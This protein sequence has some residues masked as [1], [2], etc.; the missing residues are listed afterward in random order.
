MDV[1]IREVF[2]HP[3][4]ADLAAAV[5]K[6]TP[7]TLPPI[8]AAQRGERLPLSFAQQ[9]LWFLA[10]IG[11]S[12]A[13]HIFYGLRLKGQLDRGALRRALDRIVARHE[14]L[15]TTFVS[16]EG[17]PAQRIAAAEESRFHLVEHDLPGHQMRRK[18]WISGQGRGGCE[19]D[20]ESRAADPR[21]I[22]PD[23]GRGACAADHDAPH[24][25]RRMVDGRVYQGVERAL[26]G[27]CARGSGPAA[28]AGSLQY[29]D[30]AVWQRKWMEGEILRKQGEYWER[31][32]AGAPAL[33]ELPADHPRPAEQEYAGGGRVALDEDLTRGLKELSKKHGTTLYMTLMAGWGALLARL[34]GQEDIVIGTP[35]ANRGRMEIEGLI[36]FFVNTLA[37]R[38]DVSGS[39]S[40]GDLLKRVKEQT[41]SAQQNQDIP[42]EQVVE[43]VRPVRS[44]VHSPL[45]QVMFDWQQNIGGGGLAL[46]GLEF[47]PLGSAAH[48]VAKFDLT[49]S[50]RDAGERIVGGLVYATGL[51]ERATMERY[52]GYLGAL[53]EGMVAEETQA[54]DR[55][56]LLPEAERRQ[57][58]N[59]WNATEAEYPREKLVHELFEEQVE[60]TPEAVAVVL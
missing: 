8:T 10:Q 44:L 54:V 55:L 25:F 11:A 49:L 18:N 41:L 9:R 56:Q 58:V 5:Q 40:V 7:A 20:L 26:R 6:A 39:P 53:L 31:T 43:V 29:A 45:F 4:L 3:V 19:F 32:L 2:E 22:D 37:L 15:R 12:E 60:K 42:F 21:A 59:E 46:P 27:V 23:G 36:G 33:L 1:T 14:A 16:I 13:Y 48:V 17:E 24:R 57:I 52:L 35:V 28:G 34:S 50:L 51:F 30:Y 47:G 38:L